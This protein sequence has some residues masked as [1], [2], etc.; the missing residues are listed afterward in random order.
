MLYERPDAEVADEAWARFLK[1]NQ[2]II[3]DHLFGQLKSHI[4]CTHCGHSSVTFDPFSSLSVPLRGVPTMPMCSRDNEKVPERMELLECI[5]KF[6][7]DE[8]LQ[9]GE[10]WNCSNCQRRRTVIKKLEL[11]KAPSVLII[12]L[13]RF[14]YAQVCKYYALLYV[15]LCQLYFSSSENTFVEFHAYDH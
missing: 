10:A 15:A 2:S 13:K 3:V 11:W 7:E 14:Q 12:H 6:T 9:D 8:I 1:R 4:T 5:E